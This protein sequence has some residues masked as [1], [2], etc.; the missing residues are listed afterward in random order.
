VAES[1]DGGHEI[2]DPRPRGPAKADSPTTPAEDLTRWDSE[3]PQEGQPDDAKMNIGCQ[4]LVNEALDSAVAAGLHLPADREAVAA[5]LTDVLL[6]AT[7]QTMKWA[8]EN[9][10]KDRVPPADVLET[11]TAWR[12]W[13]KETIH[14]AVGYYAQ[15]LHDIE[16][17]RAAFAVDT[18][19]AAVREDG[20][21]S[22]TRR[23]ANEHGLA[24]EQWMPIA[25]AWY[26]TRSGLMETGATAHREPG[27]D[28]RKLLDR[29][30]DGARTAAIE[31]LDALEALPR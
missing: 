18:A 11:I 27:T 26:R 23:Y 15:G 5:E 8:F 4:A 10:P 31:T 19:A 9:A 7:Q 21:F 1:T 20:T 25:G 24:E 22:E 17:V 13:S 3:V 6:G 16:E 2:P 28:P 29:L 12:N 14:F 30:A